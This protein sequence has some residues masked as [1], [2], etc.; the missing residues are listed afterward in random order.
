MRLYNFKCVLAF[1]LI[2]QQQG[3]MAE[4]IT[5]GTGPDEFSIDFLEVGNPNNLGSN[6]NDLG[7]V[8]YTYKISKYEISTAILQAFNAN[9]ASYSG[10]DYDPVPITFKNWGTGN[11]SLPGADVTWLEA[12]RFVNYLNESE[13]FQ[14]AYNF[15]NSSV[16]TN[17]SLWDS[18]E[19]WQLGGENLYRHK[20]ARY[21]LP[22]SDEW[23]KAA[24]YN[25]GTS[26]Y[27]SFPTG[28]ATPTPVLS[29]TGANEAVY[30]FGGVTPTGPAPVTMAGGTSYY[31]AMG[32]AG[33]VNEW[34]ETSKLGVFDPTANRIALGG[35]YTS[36]TETLISIN[37]QEDRIPASY[38]ADFVGFRVAAYVPPPPPSSVPEPISLV[39]LLMGLPFLVAMWKKSSPKVVS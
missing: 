30:T 5:F 36:N 19:A 6:A 26:T 9:A 13:G 33:N 12:A 20:D 29:G 27:T 31:G 24:Y 21:F 2:C 4:M 1:C 10:V 3:L 17:I 18:S 37:Y 8:D 39:M 16:T 22:T 28:D 38:Q 34:V 25:A 23:A 32:M 14:A 15:A 35:G 7:K 11:E